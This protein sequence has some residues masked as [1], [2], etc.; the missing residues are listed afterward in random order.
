MLQHVGSTL[1]GVPDG[2]TFYRM[3]SIV[4]SIAVVRPEN[5]ENK[6]E[7]GFI[8]VLMRHFWRL[9]GESPK[10]ALVA[11]VSCIGELGF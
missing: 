10:D 6:T 8:G 11:P 2:E 9:L 7:P 3:T 1:Q 4:K 5:V